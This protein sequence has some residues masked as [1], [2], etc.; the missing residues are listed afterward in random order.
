ME[1]FSQWERYELGNPGETAAICV[2]DMRQPTFLV[3]D[4]S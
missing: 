4:K 3:P 2:A 1:S